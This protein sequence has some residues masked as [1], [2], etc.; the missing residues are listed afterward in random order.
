MSVAIGFASPA[1]AT[2]P[3]VSD[4]TSLVNPF[5]G[6]ADGGDTF[7]GADTP[8]GMVQWSPDTTRQAD[9]GGYA[10]HSPSIIGYSLT[11]L[12]GPGCPADGDVPVLP[13]VGAIGSDPGD[14]TAPLSHNDETASPGYYQ[15][16]AGD[17]NTQLTATTRSGMASFSFPST[18][19]EG[20]LLFKLS[21]SANG[22]TASQFGVVNSHEVDGWVTSGHFCG[23]SETYTL[24]FDMI[25]DHAFASSG[26]WQTGGAG[27]YVTFDTAANPVVEAKV[28]ISYV[29]TANAVLNRRVENPGWSFDSVAAAA[30][31]AWQAI[32][33][34]VQVGGG[35][36]TE[37]T[38]FY[39]ALYHSLLEPNVFS[40]AN[41]QYMGF[42]GQV[43]RV[44]A[45][46]TAQYADYSGWDVYRSEIQL[47]A[48][49]A[50]HQTSD[51]VT[52]MLNDDAQSGQLPKWAQNNGETYTMVGDPADGIIAD[53]YAFGATD[54]NTRQALTDMETEATD[55][56]NIRPGLSVYEDDGYLPVDGTYGCCN[57]YG[58]GVDAGGVRRR[59][60]RNRPIRR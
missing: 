60:Q 36:P 5:V 56:N 26:T 12:S 43:H 40:D 46:Q 51:I 33:G 17:V 34:K 19:S 2:S 48:L 11:H 21:Q 35:T 57:F 47:E 44:A 55:P 18:A 6:T 30:R 38:V 20:T 3:E 42:D 27:A 9:G 54:F 8:F 49:L 37:Q 25:F 22:V 28:G 53:A 24:Y 15:L 39:T 13:T 58:A 41:G 32:L 59:R 29:S 4:P 7:P 31:R 52:S 1:G 14:V 10:Y 23:A 50:P 16:D 45:P